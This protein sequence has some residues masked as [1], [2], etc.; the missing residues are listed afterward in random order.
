MQLSNIGI[1]MQN[2]DIQSELMAKDKSSPS[3][4]FTIIQ[5][6]MILGSL[7]ILQFCVAPNIEDSAWVL[8]HALYQTIFFVVVA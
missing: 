7:Y 5:N 6:L 4:C 3:G 1:I 8:N 2:K